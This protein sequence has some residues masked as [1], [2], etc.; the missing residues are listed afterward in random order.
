LDITCSIGVA[1]Y[2]DDGAD[3]QTL[4]KHADSS[5]YRA[6]ERGRNNYQFFT[7]E[8]NALMTERLEMESGLRRALERE[9][10]RLYYQPRIDLKT[11]KL[12]GA[13]ALI[14]WQLSDEELV[15]PARFIPVAE[16]TG[17]IVPIGR[18][19][20]Q[21]ACAQSKTW[22]EAGLPPFVVS[23]NVSPRQF[24]REDLIQV[25]AEA[26]RGTR[27][28]SS[29][30]EI[31]LTES[32]VM[33]NAER[34]IDMLCAIKALGVQISVDD[35]GTGYSSLSYLQRFP[36]D[37][38]KVD[39]SFVKDMLLDRDGATIVRT[40]IAL[41]HNLGLK[42]VAEGVE[43][44][45]QVSYLR[46]NGCDELQGYYFAKPMSAEDFERFLRAG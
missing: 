30:L 15:P 22:Q 20:L 32:V 1:L 39:R 44:E 36:V 7:A 27:L 3:A 43:S 5:M 6:K 4:L 9:Q 34:L 11:G 31:E 35:F 41:G 19:A 13:E 2:P 26:L 28:E 24:Q 33:H 38:L 14:R 29:Y 10:F 16:E 25:I 18:W 37:R 45:E 40:I 23:V 12:V 21:T 42:V 8:L 46:D 17:L